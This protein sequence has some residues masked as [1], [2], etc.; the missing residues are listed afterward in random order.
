MESI[1]QH[2]DLL[3]ENEGVVRV[4]FLIKGRLVLPPELTRR[5]IEA[6][7]AATPY[8]TR[9]LELADAQVIREPIIERRTMQRTSEYQYQVLPRVN[10]LELIETDIDKLAN[11]PYTITVKAVLDLLKAVSDVLQNNEVTTKRIR[12][13]TRHTSDHPDL[14]IDGAFASLMYGL[15]VDAARSIIDNELAIW[16]IPGRHFLEGW[17]EVPTEVMPGLTSFLAQMLPGISLHESATPAFIRAMPTRQLHITSGNAPE[18]P[19]ISALRLILSKSVGAIKLP[20]GATLSGAMLA[21][22]AMAAAPNH[23]LIQNLSIVYWPGGDEDIESVLCAPGMFDRIV[24]WG[25]PEAVAS[26][27]ARAPFTKTICF[28]PRYGVSLIGKEAFEENLD[29]VAFAAAADV[30]IYSQKA[31]TSSYVQYVE[32]TETQVKA[33]AKCLAKILHQWDDI[34]PTFVPPEVRGQVK[35]MKRGKYLSADW[36]LNMEEGEFASG[37]VCM[38]SEFDIRDHP[39]SRL[40]VVRHMASL[41]DALCYLHSGVSTVGVYPEIRR[42]DLRDLIAARGVSN[43]LPLGQCERVF[44]AMPHDGMIVLA[45]LVDWKNG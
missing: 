43:I 35:R 45:E 27:Q 3:I 18:V 32:G 44:P 37:V 14:Y 17:V 16:Q 24:V 20:F 15:N 26:I 5:E 29:V 9:H 1:C 8:E 25:S 2:N 36:L 40:V 19:W 41:I 10:P 11:G 22:A 34:A 6:A 39:R 28:N 4:P 21:V 31:C 12:D 30:M 13:L 7:F 42:H 23:P 38:D 33:Y